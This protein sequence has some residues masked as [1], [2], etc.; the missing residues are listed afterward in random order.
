[1]VHRRIA[2]KVKRKRRLTNRRSCCKNDKVRILPAI[3]HAVKRCESR[4]N[5]SHILILVTQVFNSLYCLY[6]YRIDS[7]EILPK[8]I[9]GDLEE[10]VF[11]IVQQIEYIS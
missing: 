11:R 10:F 1:R 2:C 7:I 5:T 9:V 3:R 6:E 4:W 8:V